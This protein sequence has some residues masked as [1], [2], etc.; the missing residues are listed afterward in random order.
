M[1]LRSL[2]APIDPSL[3]A[4]MDVSLLFALLVQHAPPG[5]TAFSVEIVDDCA[6]QEACD[7]AR[8]SD[9]YSAWTRKES[10]EHGAKRYQEIADALVDTARELLCRAPDDGVLQDC[11]TAKGVIDPQTKRA[12]W[13]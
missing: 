7:G 11:V 10:S 2:A 5:Q 6:R 13:D 9:F 8:W 1:G 12:R 4:S 3:E